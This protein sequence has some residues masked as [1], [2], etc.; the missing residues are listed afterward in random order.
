MRKIGSKRG[1]RRLFVLP[2]FA[3]AATIVAA[4]AAGIE[5]PAEAAS[6]ATA[7][8]Y[9]VVQE[10]LTPEG[11]ARLADAF[12]IDNALLPNGAFAYVDAAQ[13]A[14]VPQRKVEEGKDE[15][16][17]PTL[18]QALDLEAVAAI[19]PISDDDAL[20]RAKQLLDVADLSPDLSA[21]AVV[22]HS[23]LT[24]ADREGRPTFEHALDTAVSFHLSLGGLP[25]TGQGAKLRITFAPDGSVSQL[26]DTLRKVEFA[27]D[28]PV[29]DEESA[30]AGCAALYARGVQQGR[31][32]LGY[33]LPDLTAKEASGDGSVRMLLPA[34]TCNPVSG[35]GS[36][37]HRLLPAVPGSTPHAK[38]TATRS[39]GTVAGYAS[40][41][42]GTPPYAYSWSS[43]TTLIPAASNGGPA[44]KYAMRPR[45]RSVETLSLEVT[46]ANGLSATASVSLPF[47]GASSAEST[48]GGG[49]F[50][51]LAIGPT[52]VGIEQTV[53]EWACAQA[54]GDGFKSVMAS[55]G[56]G[57]AFDWRGANAFEKDF[58]QGAL[59]GWDSSYVDNVDAQWYTGHGWSGGFTFKSSVDDGSI[60][61]SDARWGDGDLEWLQLESCQVL[62]D[63]NGTHDYFSRWGPA[64]DGLHILNGFHTNAY[65]VGGG[66]GGRFA[67]YL[68]PYKWLGITL[69]P[70][71]TVRQAWANMA[72]DKEPTGVVYRSMGPL[73]YGYTSNMSDY[74]WGQ[75]SV[76]PDIPAASRTGFWA[77][78]GT[79]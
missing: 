37:A 10:G 44:V 75:G 42:G 17:N 36:Q 29:I 33:Y 13:F 22:S 38:V 3:A 21:R 18:S 34:Y 8:A 53:D 41:D 11:G 16:G 19:R 20:S 31:P 12:K 71:L 7:P 45:Y 28:V 68:F 74:F 58:K 6:Y 73:G 49:G 30:V 26:S 77:V 40:V 78:S 62:R 24:L 61:P 27:G 39:Y 35:E 63:T 51:A 59:G 57:A 79:V 25:A 46:D 56:I 47:D 54:S 60:V 9:R 66:T 4:I 43:S 76:G 32:T 52:D 2:A 48:P 65:C 15:Q 70:A 1:A 50:G 23:E 72:L 14:Q 67:E 55:H 64:F 69:R 5:R